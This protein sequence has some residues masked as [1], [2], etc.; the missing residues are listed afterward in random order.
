[1]GITSVFSPA[2]FFWN[3]INGA[4]D[5]VKST[6]TLECKCN[7]AL[8]SQMLSSSLL[9]LL[10]SC[11]SAELWAE[12]KLDSNWQAFCFLVDSHCQIIHR[13]VKLSWSFTFHPL[14]HQKETMVCSFPQTFFKGFHAQLRTL[15]CH[16]VP[17]CV[18]AKVSE[19]RCGRALALSLTFTWSGFCHGL[20]CPR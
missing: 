17:I 16:P 6:L 12:W 5:K 15:F 10:L 11:K 20:M 3:Q 13:L 7:R 4:M 18:L 2:L 1:M 8:L 14:L 19:Q 9:F